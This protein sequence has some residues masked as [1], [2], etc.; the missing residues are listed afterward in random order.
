MKLKEQKLETVSHEFNRGLMKQNNIPDS[1]NGGEEIDLLEL[2]LVLLD[3]ARYIVFFALIGALLLNMYAFFLIPPT[4]QSTAKMYIASASNDSV[5]DLTDL[6]IGTSLTKDYEELMLSYPVLD[7]VIEELNL[8]MNYTALAKLI[9]ISNVTDTRILQITVTSTDRQLSCDIANTLVSVSIDYLPKTM[10]TEE[11]NIAQEAR[12]ALVKSDPSYLKYTF[13]GAML[14][15]ILCC[16]YIICRYLLDDTI[17]TADDMKKYF[18][19]TPLAVIPDA[20]A[21]HEGST[22]NKKKGRR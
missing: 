9:E 2:A 22:K 1:L 6:N 14:G 8:D 16:A 3:K 10:S 15:A 20:E 21:L 19:V 13:L 18:G 7:Q 11:P 4:Y 5:V 12:T 17:H